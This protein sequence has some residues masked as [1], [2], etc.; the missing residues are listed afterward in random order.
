MRTLLLCAPCGSSTSLE[1]RRLNAIRLVKQGHRPAKVA[2]DLGVSAAA[3]SQWVKAY[4]KG[5]RRALIAKAHRR[6][7]AKLSAKQEQWLSHRLRQG[8]YGRPGRWT[9]SRV[10]HE[11]KRELGI[12]LE[13]TSVWRLLRR[14][15]CRCFRPEHKPTQE[16]LERWR[17]E[18]QAEARR[19]VGD[20]VTL[21]EMLLAAGKLPMPSSK[22][23]WVPSEDVTPC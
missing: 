2:R 23:T 9:T 1:Q 14:L 13:R 22:S 4:E 21:T 5:G 10:Q 7:R 18:V 11:I 8:P 3:V 6:G 16:E 19:T 15:G 12:E 20:D 17:E